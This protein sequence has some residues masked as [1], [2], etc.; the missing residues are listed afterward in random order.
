MSEA[1]AA[2]SEATSGTASAADAIEMGHVAA[3]EAAREAARVALTRGLW[4]GGGL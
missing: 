3:R 4:R 1:G 2:T